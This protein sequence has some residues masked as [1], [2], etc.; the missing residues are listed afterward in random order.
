MHRPRRL[1]LAAGFAILAGAVA[2]T[3]S[4]TAPVMLQFGD[5]LFAEGRYSEARTA[6][7]AAQETDDQAIRRL[8]AMGTVRS[9]LRLGA[10]S[11]AMETAASL[12]DLAPDDAAVLALYGDAV[13][14]TGLFEE[15]EQAY[16][17]T[18]ELVPDLAQAHHGVARTLAAKNQLDAALEEA[19]IALRLEP[20]EGEF[21]H[22][23][24]SILERMRRYGEAVSAFTAYLSLLPNQDSG[25]QAT[26]GRS[27]IRFL[28]SFGE[29]LPM[30]ILDEGRERIH[31]IPFK[32]SDDK[33]IVRGRVNDRQNVDFV[34]DTGAEHTFLSARMAQRS[35]VTPIVRTLAAGVGQLGLRGLLLGKLDSLRIGTLRVRNVPTLIKAPRLTGNG[36]PKNERDGF[37]PLALG[38]SMSIDYQQRELV[39]AERLPEREAHTVLPLHQ[40]RLAVVR[41]L[42]NNDRAVNFIVDTGGEVISISRDTAMA[43]GPST[44]RRIPLRVFG[45]SGWDTDAFLLPGV[46]L[47]FNEIEYN[48][49]SVV[50]LNLQAPSTL[51]GF[52][53][54]GIV[55][56]KFLSRYHVDID[57]LRSEVRLSS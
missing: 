42:V 55:G 24:G 5:L 57:L 53:V 15:A 10:F 43:L 51:L 30:E 38:L 33:I 32:V 23:A 3:D 12:R 21:H 13:W 29:D 46:D 34:L 37:S 39:V 50:V 36:L 14:A 41:G 16:A 19:E 8:G 48:N 26:L 47:R 25:E 56:H 44:F 49:F 54:G 4:R 17:E 2:S 52:Q 35:R 27:K 31:R 6:Y 22:T 9:S 45:T 18:L 28:R 1:L 7:E 20:R 40:H 11:R